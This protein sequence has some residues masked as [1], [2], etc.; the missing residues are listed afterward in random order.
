[1]DTVSA[2]K[3]VNSGSIPGRVKPK[4]IELGIHSIL[5]W[6]MDRASAAKTVDPNSIPGRIKLKAKESAKKPR[7]YG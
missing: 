7:G 4:A 2:I 3:M 1:M 6:R 5:A